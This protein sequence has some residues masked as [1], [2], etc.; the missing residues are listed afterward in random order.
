MSVYACMLACVC[1]CLRV[2]WTG[3]VHRKAMRV[4][5][6]PE[7]AGERRIALMFSLQGDQQL[8]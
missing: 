8:I 4:Y 1:V 2:E 3:T 6:T 5:C 7:A